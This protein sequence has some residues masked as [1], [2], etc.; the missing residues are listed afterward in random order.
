M[1]TIVRHRYL[2]V[3][4]G[5]FVSG[6]ACVDLWLELFCARFPLLFYLIAA[7]IGLGAGHKLKTWLIDHGALK[8]VLKVVSLTCC[9]V[10]CLSIA[11]LTLMQPNWGT[12]CSFRYC[13]RGLSGLTLLASPYPVGK[14]SCSALWLCANEYRLS[15]SQKKELDRLIEVQGC[16]VP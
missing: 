6:V 15:S 13:G 10:G 5:F 1:T 16:P 2:F 8:K 9:F 11:Q 14:L 4:S 12:K 3:G 7:I